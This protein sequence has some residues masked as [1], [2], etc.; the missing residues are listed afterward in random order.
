MTSLQKRFFLYVVKQRVEAGDSPEKATRDALN[1]L[2]R[3]HHGRNVTR[4]GPNARRAR[5]AEPE[6][7]RDLF[8]RY[9][10]AMAE[11]REDFRDVTHNAGVVV[12]AAARGALPALSDLRPVRTP[13]GGFRLGGGED[14][15]ATPAS[16]P[17]KAKRRCRVR[18]LRRG[19]AR[20]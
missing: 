2:R 13:I 14:A 10:K 1:F 9:R 17:R 15:A 16:G 5:D 8:A 6:T 7:E 3:I 19:A 12:K 18:K 11:K 20:A 4:V